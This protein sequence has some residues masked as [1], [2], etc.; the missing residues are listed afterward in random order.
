[1]S[2]PQAIQ[3]FDKAKV[4]A[5]NRRARFDYFVEERFEGLLPDVPV[6]FVRAARAANVH[7]LGSVARLAQALAALPADD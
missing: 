1:M 2:K 4:V 5:E 6:E 3:E 7:D